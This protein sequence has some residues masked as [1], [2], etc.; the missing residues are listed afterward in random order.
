MINITLAMSNSTNRASKRANSRQSKE[1]GVAIPERLLAR[2]WQKRAVRQAEFRTSA[3]RRVR[4]L[5]PGRAGTAAGPDFRNALLE[6]E[7][8]G[9]VQGDVEMHLRHQD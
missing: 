8:T 3:G 4:V 5:Y 6:I 1:S 7:G 2:L 9:L